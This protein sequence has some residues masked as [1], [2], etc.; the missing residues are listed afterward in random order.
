[1]KTNA[2]VYLISL[3]LCLFLKSEKI[4]A[5]SD[6]A[7]YSQNFIMKGKMID[8]RDGVPLSNTKI[9]VF[10]FGKTRTIMTNEKGEYEVKFYDHS[11]ESSDENYIFPDGEL[12]FGLS[13]DPNVTR[14]IYLK[15]TKLKKTSGKEDFSKKPVI[16]KINIKLDYDF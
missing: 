10:A 14:T 16:L 7:R 12:F 4:S 8:G 11:G 13:T 5:Q 9:F 2:F 15:N 6:S 3:I 1:M